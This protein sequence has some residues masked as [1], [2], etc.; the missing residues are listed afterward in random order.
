MVV[1]PGSLPVNQI[2]QKKI[3]MLLKFIASLS[4]N[5]QKRRRNGPE[6]F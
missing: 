6:I 3:R 5:S 2:T 4:N 1:M